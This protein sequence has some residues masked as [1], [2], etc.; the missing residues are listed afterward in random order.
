MPKCNFFQGHIKSV[1]ADQQNKIQFSAVE[2]FF[3][4]KCQWYDTFSILIEAVNLQPFVFFLVTFKS[5]IY[6]AMSNR[7]GIVYRGKAGEIF[8]III[9]VVGPTT[10]IVFIDAHVS[11][12]RKKGGLRPQWNLM[13]FG[14]WWWITSHGNNSIFLIELITGLI[15]NPN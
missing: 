4:T 15:S 1:S 9:I 7:N 11:I 5:Q 12:N 10:L 2:V 14:S 13:F 3:P 8:I 6:F